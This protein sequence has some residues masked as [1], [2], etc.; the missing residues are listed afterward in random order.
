MS[1]ATF[2]RGRRVMITGGLGFIGSNLAHRLVQLGADVLL[3]DSLIPEYGGNLFNIAGI[4]DRVTVNV[5][6]VRQASTMNYL[7][8]GRE[9]IF[10]LAGQVSHIDSMRDP[11]TDLEINCRSQLTLL[12]ACRHHN[13]A[14]KVIFAST[15]QI[16]GKPD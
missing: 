7:V 11:H 6:D 5:A 3:V 9:V 4:E 16:Y 14:A 10:N 15:R 2:Y 1:A 13:P 8:Q 12:E